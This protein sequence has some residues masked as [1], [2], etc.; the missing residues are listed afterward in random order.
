MAQFMSNALA[1]FS[2]SD[3]DEEHDDSPHYRFIKDTLL[4]NTVKI[5]KELRG[6]KFKEIQAKLGEA[7]VGMHRF[8]FETWPPDPSD[9]KP[10]DATPH[11]S[12]D[13]HLEEQQ[14]QQQQQ[15][16][17]AGSDEED[18]ESTIGDFKEAAKDD[19][20]RPFD[21]ISTSTY[22]TAKTTSTN[23]SHSVESAA[24]QIRQ[25]QQHQHQQQQQQQQPSAKVELEDDPLT[26]EPMDESITNAL[27]AY[28]L[29]FT[30]PQKT[31]KACELALFCTTQLVKRGYLS[32]RA[33]GQ[34]DL[35]GSGPSHRET[36]VEERP[37]PSLLHQLMHAI[38]KCGESA[39]DSVQTHVIACFQA[40][41]MSPKCS[42]HEA[43]LLLVIRSIFHIY[44][45]TKNPS[46]QQKSKSCLMEICSSIVRKMED[47][48]LNENSLFY[49]DSY[50]L[51]RSLVKLSSKALQGID[52][53]DTTASNF[54]TRQIFTT[55]TFDPLALNNK[56]LSLELI[57]QIMECAGDNIC[58]GEKFVQ[59]VQAQLCVALLKNCMSNH[60]QVA[61]I[62]QKI[63]LVLVY[64]FKTHLKDEI[65]VFMTNI[66][67]RVLQS[68][69]ST[70]A[71]KALVLES[72]RSLCN[73][74]V[75]L[76][77]IFL[78]Y[79]CD[80]D[81]M[82]LYKDILFHLTKL[83]GKS[84]EKIPSNMSKKDAEEHFELSL[85]AV[86]VLVS[87]LHSFL[88]ALN[89]P[90][91]NHSKIND[92]AGKKIRAILGLKDVGQF[93]LQQQTQDTQNQ[94]QQQLDDPDDGS[95][96]RGLTARSRS[97]S[98][99]SSD[100]S[101][102]GSASQLVADQI[103]DAFDRKRNLEQNFQMGS[104]KFTL[105]LKSGLKFFIDNGF[106]EL[107]AEQIALFFL[108]NKD[109]LDKTQMGEVLGKEPDAAFVKTPN[110]D[111]E[112]GG[113]GFFL[114]VLHHYIHSL[115]F[116]DLPFDDAIRLFLSGFRLPGEA[117]KIDRIMEKFAERFTIQNPEVFHN[118]DT[119][120]ILAFSV[121]MLNTDL[122]NPSIKPERRMTLDGFQRNNRGIGENGADLPADFLAGIFER[123]KKSPFSLK[124]DDAAREKAA[125][126][127]METSFFSDANIFGMSAEERKKK[128]FKSEREEM[129]SATEQLIRRRRGK[130]TTAE[131]SNVDSVAPSD[132][133]K[134][135]M[136]VTWG[137]IIGMLS[138]VLEFSTEERI[139]AV[140]LN[141]FVYA[142]RVAS[143]SNMSLARDTFVNS[144]AKFTLLG[145]IKEMKYKNIEAIRTLMTMAI[146][147]GEYLGESW[148][149]VL[150]CIS[151]LARMRMSASGL[152]SDESFL[153]QE[154]KAPVPKRQSNM[155]FKNQKE[156]KA[157]QSKEMA[158]M[159]ERAILETFSEQ[160]IDNVFSS[161]VKLSALSLGHFIEQLVAVSKTE[162]EGDTT[163]SI[164]G[165][166]Q[167]GEGSQH[168][169]DG[170]SIFSLQRLVDVADFN[171]DSRPRV[172]WT[173]V[174]EIMADFFAE[175]GC[176]RN[177]MV[178]VFAIDS[179]KQMS[180]KFLEKPELAETKFQRTFLKPFLLIIQNP[181]TPDSNREMVLQC[182]DQMVST[183]AHNLQSGWKVFF[184]IVMV[185]SRDSN[186]RIMVLSINILQRLL[187]DHLSQLCRLPASKTEGDEKEGKG[188]LSSSEARNRNATAEDF[189]RMCRASLAFVQQDGPQ[190]RY[191]IGISMR[192]LC[193]S[194]IYADL[195][196]EAQI[197]P[198][199][200][201]AQAEDPNA[202]GFTYDG[203]DE[204][205]A[206]EMVLW[207]P[208][209]DGLA[210]AA[211]STATS[212]AGGV[213]CLLQRGSVLAIRAIL[214]RHGSLF[215]VNQLSAILRDTITPAFKEAAENDISPVVS[216]TS[217][218]PAMSNLDFMSA[219]MPLPPPDD[220][221]GLLK[222]EEAARR[223]DAAPKRP[224]GPSELLLEACF[225]DMRHGG[226]GDLSQVYKFANKEMRGN[227]DG[228]Q[229]FPDSWI[230]TTAAVALGTLT[231]VASE[232]IVPKGKEGASKLW[233]DVA[234]MIQ[235]WCNGSDSWQPCEA[236][237][238]VACR[239]TN[240]FANR[241][242]AK[243][244]GLDSDD[245]SAWGVAIVQ[246]F[247]ETLS[248]CLDIE[249][250]LQDEIIQE[251]AKVFKRVADNDQDIAA[252]KSFES[253][254]WASLVPSL[255]IRC[256]AAHFLQ[257]ALQSLNE[258]APVPPPVA[259]DLLDALNRS[260]ELAE[261]AA[262]NEDIALA[263]QEAILSEWG[264]DE[265]DR[266][267][268]LMNVA[269]L[270]QTQGS[271]MFFMMQTAGAT[272]VMIQVL[273]ALYEG[274]ASGSSDSF[275]IPYLLDIMQDVFHKFAESE[276]TE[277]HRISGGIKVAVYCTTFSS[278]IV[279]LLKAMIAFDKDHFESQKA[280]FFPMVC[281][282]I[283]VQ[284]EEIRE[285]VQEILMTKFGPMLG[286]ASNG[287]EA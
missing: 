111:P 195:I 217:E 126:E 189:V 56:V 216:I 187:D 12:L 246:F 73:D 23:G 157:L 93:K 40:I 135:M 15:Q 143:H 19:D 155:F 80:F 28:T 74:P 279:C 50:Y 205:E 196:A 38:Q 284:S 153:K 92:T 201:G 240:R 252:A 260:R 131:K 261:A 34:D 13:E 203:L 226:D 136:D 204:K 176:H 14:Q 218:S 123:I 235:T 66:F 287:M 230:A 210:S 190:M 163:R 141:G 120:F 156:V 122:H 264:M 256:I 166:K 70:F 133:V 58:Y 6:R 259:K 36:P 202:H 68:D 262:K 30:H 184:D 27:E 283:T 21:D 154:S 229:P 137:P 269:R 180:S 232:V 209:L 192:A 224:L 63:F 227:A 211:K 267:E 191:P 9:E 185:A 233:P 231:D 212:R 265:E 51:M 248:R 145:S 84:T 144:L 159:N 253:S 182:I 7:L 228:E 183:K 94:Q 236:L 127:V 167:T 62:S 16:Q 158:E 117:Q 160:L 161:T 75:L 255:K 112:K 119:A 100:N 24:T 243:L 275:A 242:S 116:E 251:K 2:K 110:T 29:I 281:R 241:V 148:A 280:A 18:I 132:V 257:E 65:S 57:C 174:W 165:M 48:P 247:Q 194:A 272:N 181:E 85:A 76:T 67:L 102:D 43:T 188:A 91:A 193:H 276:A 101:L 254:T 25:Q 33:G 106:V 97:S 268:A 8:Q 179:L 22:A 44:L 71:Q 239:E 114:R 26:R 90:A 168:G 207:R 78:N 46:C 134:P 69:N 54:L 277:G 200:S 32:G 41:M 61:F 271:A 1:G 285:L 244:D 39:K 220:D 169:D 42:A 45:V 208:I 86:E 237:V 273:S 138:Q 52:D 89:M 150:Q 3:E 146:A 245:K 60:T 170:P 107:D 178:S 147:D 59:M 113:P 17:A 118:A 77:Q 139:I 72:L 140:C 249:V 53:K 20:L 104:I 282:L 278:T 198:P 177:Q 47:S 98:Y 175:I 103:V 152:D 219:P 31:N 274:E 96:Q 149:P 234:D 222:F 109:K 88:K 151:Q 11:K 35:S 171:M 4:P 197:L 95:V 286:V 128:K 215:S 64:K 164:T 173:Q 125:A 186:E 258:N 223:M 79:D 82:N 5:Q 221:D 49:T 105:S 87:V 83:S 206:L 129:M 81:A 162:L 142:V 130:T 199:V 263:F 55:N 115:D 214:L 213:G 250:A 225:T 124:E 10:T 270:A 121:I 238:R 266:E 99:N 172:I 108:E 37:E